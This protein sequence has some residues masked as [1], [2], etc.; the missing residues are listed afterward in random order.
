MTIWMIFNALLSLIVAG[1]L[2]YKMIYY[3]YIGTAF[4]R[5]GI[6]LIAAGLILNIGP[7]LSRESPFGNGPMTPYDD[8]ASTMVRIGL[9]IYFSARMP[10][11]ALANE[12]M[13]DWYTKRKKGDCNE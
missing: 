5:V 11:H 7:I 6:G 8:W 13:V 4:E 1:A 12:A 3:T 10:K 9:L 2:T